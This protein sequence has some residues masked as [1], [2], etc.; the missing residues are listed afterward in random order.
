MCSNVFK[1]VQNLFKWVQ[2][3]SKL[4]QMSSNVFKLVQNLFK[5]V[6]CVPACPRLVQIC[7]NVFKIVQ[8]LSAFQCK[9]SDMTSRA[10]SSFY[11]P[12]STSAPQDRA[13]LWTWECIGARCSGTCARWK[14]GAWSPP[15]SGWWDR[16]AGTPEDG[17]GILQL[18]R[19]PES[20]VPSWGQAHVP[21]W[22][23]L[24]ALLCDKT[25]Y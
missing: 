11:L 13:S 7:S 17:I 19:D 18:L 24:Q 23:A 6:K 5:C 25:T 14:G 2:T 3:F 4:A 8:K 22:S 9:G 21:L 15:E 12:A 16:I 1:L 20:P 10:W